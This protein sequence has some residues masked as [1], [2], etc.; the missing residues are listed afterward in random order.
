LREKIADCLRLL[1]L[2]LC[3]AGNVLLAAALLRHGSSPPRTA[4]SAAKISTAANPVQPETPLPSASA[5]TENAAALDFS[6]AQIYTPDFALYIEQLRG[7]GTPERQVREIIFGAVD[8]IYRPKRGALRPPV[9]KT[10]ETK[11]W[12]HP[13][14]YRPAQ[15]PTKEQRAQLRALQKEETDLLKSLFGPDVYEQ[16]AK[17]S[18][19]IDWMEKQYG[20]IPK[21][22]REKV[23]EID[24]QMNEEK[25]EIYA[26]NDGFYDSYQQDD[27]RKVEKKYHDELAKILTPEQLLEWDLRHSDTANQLKNDLSAFDPNEDEFRALFKYDQAKDDLNPP[28]D[29]DSDAPQPTADERK[30]LQEK[31]KAL[32]ADL[33]QAVGADRVKEYKLEQDYGYRSLIE[34]GVPKESVFKL[35]DMKQQAQDAA[36]KIRKDKT[37]TSDQRTA[38]L[39]AIRDATQ[40]G[41]SGLLDDKQVKRYI[42][43]GGWWL[44]NIA[45]APP[46][47]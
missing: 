11:F 44:N 15:Q 47:P 4:D 8:A 10:G 28:R 14:F 6:W 24:Q 3:L 22:L 7:F 5:T 27:L 42:N 23:Q 9:K 29:P 35:D 38:A 2:V 18:D 30:A 45:P 26:Q 37:L 19:G 40:T 20:F 41:M 16:R 46:K 31:Q 12:E 33:A 43:N 32:D 21:A 1:L 25:G 34:S 13:R 39:T 36:N 17:D